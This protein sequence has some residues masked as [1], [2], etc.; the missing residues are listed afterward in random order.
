MSG[1]SG[2]SSSSRPS[3]TLELISCP[4]WAASCDALLVYMTTT[5]CSQEAQQQNQH[6]CVTVALDC[7]LPDATRLGNY[8]IVLLACITKDTFGTKLW[9]HCLEDQQQAQ[10][11][12][13]TVAPDPRLMGTSRLSNFCNALSIDMTQGFSWDHKHHT[14]MRYIQVHP[15]WTIRQR[16]RQVDR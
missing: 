10:L 7:R 13:F 6:S 9:N 8:H 4:D 12:P 3:P 11:S 2:S 14:D 5:R 16:H 1:G 15:F